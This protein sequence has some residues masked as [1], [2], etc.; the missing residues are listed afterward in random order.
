MRTAVWLLNMGGP[1]SVETIQPF[2]QNLLADG[3]IIQFPWYLRWAQPIF[4]WIISRKRAREVRESYASMGG[5]SPQLELVREQTRALQA[6]LG[7]SYDCHPVFRYW[8]ESAKDAAAKLQPGQPV[9]LLSLY[10]Q[11][12]DTTVG[13]SVEDA[14]SVLAGHPVTVI[15]SYPDDPRYIASLV[16]Q[17]RALE[18]TT[19]TIL[20]SAHGLPKA[21]IEQG[22]PYLS[23]IER[24]VAAIT[25]ELPNP[26]TLSFQSRVGVQEW[27]AP[28]SIEAIQTL[29]EQGI[30]SLIVVPVAFTSDHIETLVEIGEELKELAEESGI[31]TFK[32]VEAPNSRPDFIAALAE[33]VRGSTDSSTDPRSG[34]AEPA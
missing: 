34:G 2:L 4:A 25:A 1:D 15:R 12:S 20:F 14:R 13:S 22:D 8:G 26:H 19:S 18:D 28:S 9:V 5:A 24:T 33:I 16:A 31:H 10:P 21:Y 3:K 30:T 29:G 11:D 6:E 27:L 17:I 23:E 7:Q 32:R